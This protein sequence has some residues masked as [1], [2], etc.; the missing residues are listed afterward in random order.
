M[1]SLIDQTRRD[2]IELCKTWKE[3]GLKQRQ[4]LQR[5]VFPENLVYTMKTAFFASRNQSIM[6]DLEEI[7]RDWR[8][9]GV[10]DGI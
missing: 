10:P 6:Q 2:A 5:V 4:E 1:E 9:V 7:Y 8:T 3:A